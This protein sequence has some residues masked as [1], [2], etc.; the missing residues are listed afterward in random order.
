MPDN[1]DLVPVEHDPFED[2]HGAGPTGNVAG[3]L[4]GAAQNWWQSQPS[5]ASQAHEQTLRDEAAYQAGG[6]QALLHQDPQPALDLMGGF[7][8]STTPEAKGI[9]AY[10]GS[11]YDFDRFDLSKIGGGAG[12]WAWAVFCGSRAGSRAVSQQTCRSAGYIDWGPAGATRW[13]FRQEP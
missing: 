8:G 10:H 6:P 1:Y 3:S 13:L 9:T 2:M 12:L 11:P 4:L 7:V 5:W